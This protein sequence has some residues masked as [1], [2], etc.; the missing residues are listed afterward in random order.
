MEKPKYPYKGMSESQVENIQLGNATSIEKCID[1][2]KVDN[3]HKWKKYIWD[4]GEGKKL[5]ATIY[6]DDGYGKVFEVEK[7][8][9]DP[10][11]NELPGY[12]E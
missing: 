3:T 8:P 5:V 4:Y 6:Y 7:Y 1:F 9:I 10:Y 11:G 2:S 12:W